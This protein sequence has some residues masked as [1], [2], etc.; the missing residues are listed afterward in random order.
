MQCTSFSLGTQPQ[1]LP[2]SLYERKPTQLCSNKSMPHTHKRLYSHLYSVKTVATGFHSHSW[3]NQA[4]NT[5]MNINL[6]NSLTTYLCYRE[7]G[8]SL[9]H[10]LLT[11]YRNVLQQAEC[12]SYCQTIKNTI[13][14]KSAN[15]TGFNKAF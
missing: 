3:E 14:L 7:Q 10:H 8:M 1:I 12:Y 4:K 9:L 2:R 5:T 11:N 13:D 6:V 15:Q